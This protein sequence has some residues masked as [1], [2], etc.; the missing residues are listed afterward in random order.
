MMA[1]VSTFLFS[2]WFISQK[3]SDIDKRFKESVKTEASAEIKNA[4][5]NSIDQID[6]LATSI[7]SWDE[8]HQQL[9]N[10]AYYGYW[11][12]Q[13]VSSR[14]LPSYVDDIDLYK[15]NLEILGNT[16]DEKDDDKLEYIDNHYTIHNGHL[17]HI[18]IYPIPY[19]N[20]PDEINGYL[21]VRTNVVQSLIQTS[22]LVVTDPSSIKVSGD[23][24]K[25]IKD[26]DILNYLY[27]AS[28][29][30][31]IFN[32]LFNTTKSTLIYGFSLILLFT[33]ILY[34]I[35]RF[36][37][38]N[39]LAKLTNYVE[40]LK[41]GVP[42]NTEELIF[43]V[44]EFDNLKKSIDNYQNELTLINLNLDKKNDELWKLAHRD[45]LT[46]A[47]NR[48]AYD[49]D[50]NSYLAIA[51]NKRFA[52]S[53]MLI[54][55][56]HFKAIN[57]TY[58]HDT[59]DK[60]ISA[61][62]K[63]LQ[64]SLRD[65]DKLYRIGGDEFVTILWNTDTSI[66]DRVAQ[67]CLD[68][69]RNYSFQPLGINEPITISIGIATYSKDSTSSMKALP[70]QADIAMYH[71]KKSGSRSIIHYNASLETDLA[72]LVSN[73][74][75]DAVIKAANTAEG[76]SIHYQPIVN[77]KTLKIDYYEALLRIIDNQGLIS[78][79]DIFPVAEKL[80]LEAEIDLSVLKK[81]EY[82]L[83]HKLLP[84]DTG[85]SINFSAA[86]FSL[87]NLTQRL[88]SFT[89]YLSDYTIIFEVTEKTLI[90]DLKMVS[91]Q[92][93]ELQQAGFQ[94]ALDDFGSGY[95]SIRYL[96]NMPID[97]VKFDISMTKQL[98][99]ETKSRSIISGTAGVIIKSGFKLVAEGIENS[100][101]QEL[102]SKMG[103]THMQ[104][105][106]LGKPETID[107]LVHDGNVFG[108]KFQ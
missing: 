71:A 7:I 53:Y 5:K 18:A 60:V 96:A 85:V 27:F 16:G 14:T 36:I 100:Q 99:A 86:L 32:E 79:R 2:S 90:T 49:D 59:G 63:I 26:S 78:A 58:G 72:P 89:Q 44:Y 103:A 75:I 3:I 93:T 24:K 97:I 88:Q 65:G 30:N 64:D 74:V 105:Y 43:E 22:K 45:S 66:A 69:L 82:D 47:A 81:I 80:A 87:P 11:K 19:R 98:A 95:S 106:A 70:R 20:N 6:R 68:N 84:M 1:A 37:I 77:A 73:R 108:L 52:F 31:P 34:Y 41:T 38:N 67:R 25:I 28:K 61:L 39:P 40:K 23:Q 9:A 92:L 42:V 17:Y 104:G 46:G 10:P 57:D 29:R 76:I 83:K 62:V 4:I 13:R 33:S 101:L 54:D 48:R 94:I 15:K 51:D 35:A 21:L 102:V 56:N 107:K 50:W 12:E 55:C 8:V 91:I